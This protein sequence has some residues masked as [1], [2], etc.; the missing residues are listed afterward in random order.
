MARK[1]K[2]QVVEE[3]EAVQGGKKKKK[4]KKKLL[5]IPIVLIVVVAVAAAAVLFILPRV[6]IDLLGKGGTE[7]EE[8]GAPPKKGITA[9]TIGEDT[10]PSLDTILEEGEGEI[11]AI[12][13][14]GE[15]VQKD[16][17]TGEETT[18]EVYTYIY[19][20]EGY[21]AVMD[22]YLDLLMGSEQ[23]F[24]L[25]DETYL[26]LE[27]RPELEDAQ[28]GLLLVKKST[29][30]GRLFQLAIGWSQMSGNMAVR[31]AAP[32][33]TLHYPEKEPEEQP[34]PASLPEQMDTLRNMDPYKLALS[35]SSM[36]EYDIASTTG[37]VK[38]DGML[39]R[40]FTIYKKD[41]NGSRGE[42]VG[43][44]YLS[45]DQQHI[46]QQEKD[47]NGDLIITELVQ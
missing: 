43:I 36:E 9:Y 32:E 30:E 26:V 45:G 29:Q 25:A 27:E 4:G 6:G 31:V 8:L 24:V 19:E 35:G 28:G 14:P 22:R 17:E 20:L 1:K 41:A 47:E 16:E 2:K 15:V 18:V 7:D 10:V 44:I 34:K 37:F 42:I 11:I 3:D 23:G 39:C 40:R 46:F 38:I 5:L 21:A 13:G 33:E 12:R